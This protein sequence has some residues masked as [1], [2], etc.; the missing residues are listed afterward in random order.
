M[1]IGTRGSAL[2]LAQSEGVRASLP[3]DPREHR[4]VIIKTA[5]DLQPN[6][7]LVRIGG[8]GVFTKEIEEALLRREIDIAVH[9]LKDL[10]TDERPGLKLGAL[11]A[12]DDPRDALVSREGLLFEQLRQGASIGTSS[13]RRR[14]QI[15]AHRPDLRVQD[16][17][18]NVPTRLARLEGGHLDAI[19]VAAAGLHRLNLI[20][21]ATQVLEEAVMLPAPGQGILAIQIRADDKATEAA[22]AG[23]N[24]AHAA[25][26]ATAERA[27]LEGLGGGCLVPVGARARAKDGML[28]LTAYVGHPDGRPSVRLGASGPAGAP[29]D[30]GRTLAIALLGQGARPILDEVRSMERFP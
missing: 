17:R 20:D 7:A 13:L 1:R 24:D 11:L 10:P 16:L 21:R 27:L 29:A 30:L 4:L 26:E 14:S 2:A 28:E 25:A 3:G 9:S 6:A 23:L 5:G 22:I 8:K 18:G 15:L 12:R 19:I